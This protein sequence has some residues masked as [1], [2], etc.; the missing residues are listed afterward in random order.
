[1]VVDSREKN[2]EFVC[3][4]FTEYYFCE[5]DCMHN[6]KLLHR[7]FNKTEYTYILR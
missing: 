5:I 3:I 1:M 6:Q 2:Y 7:Y 4:Q